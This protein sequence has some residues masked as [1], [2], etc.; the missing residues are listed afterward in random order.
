MNTK[1]RRI[2][3]GIAAIVAG[4]L[5]LVPAVG[6]D[7]A[8]R[9]SPDFNKRPKPVVVDAYHHPSPDFDK[10]PKPAAFNLP[11]PAADDVPQCDIHRTADTSVTSLRSIVV[12]GGSGGGVTL[13][14]AR[15]T[16]S[17]V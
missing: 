3:I 10:R 11:C 6:V 2:G 15:M 4:T 16:P 13:N 1:Y 17:P 14:V 8:N 12:A 9:P 7:A 5:A